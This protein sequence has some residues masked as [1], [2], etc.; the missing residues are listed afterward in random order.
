MILLSAANAAAL[1]PQPGSAPAA[2]SAPASAAASA[3]A[4]AAASAALGP[5]FPQ[6]TEPVT[7][8]NL[9]DDD[10]MAS[11]ISSSCAASRQ[12]CWSRASS[13]AAAPV[14][15]AV[16]RGGKPDD[17]GRGRRRARLRRSRVSSGVA[18][19]LRG[20]P[21]TTSARS[22]TTG[23]S[24]PCWHPRQAAAACRAAAVAAQPACAARLALLVWLAGQNYWGSLIMGSGSLKFLRFPGDTDPMSIVLNLG[25]TEEAP[26]TRARARVPAI[27]LWR[28]L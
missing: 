11:A 15:G 4:G 2:T 5:R 12:R 25:K 21:R 10:A 9:P 28:A 22:Y 17:A 13:G 16:G 8:G 3:A 14:E 26:W 6:T 23:P 18:A 20:A 27:R 7:N 19:P 24:P 1:P